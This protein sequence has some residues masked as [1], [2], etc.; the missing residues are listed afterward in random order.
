M[1]LGISKLNLASATKP[2]PDFGQGPDPYQ[3]IQVHEYMNVSFIRQ[4]PLVK[5][6][7]S[8]GKIREGTKYVA[9][10]NYAQPS[11]SSV[12]TI[13]RPCQGSSSSLYRC[14]CSGCKS[15]ATH[16]GSYSVTNISKVHCYEAHPGQR[17]GQEVHRHE[18]SQST[19]YRTRSVGAK[20][21]RWNRRAI[22]DYG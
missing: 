17:N 9:N 16:I 6:A 21:I 22:G 5:A 19:G 18:L 10:A 11:K 2:I 4:D 15:R 20:S 7:S 1:E 13:P 12:L 14:L 3:G 8:K